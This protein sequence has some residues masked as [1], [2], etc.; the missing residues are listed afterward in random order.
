MILDG[1]VNDGDTIQVG[2]GE[3]GLVINGETFAKAA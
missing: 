1:T 2:A 3:G